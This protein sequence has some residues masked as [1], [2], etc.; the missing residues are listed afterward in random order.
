M[1]KTL[2]IL[3]AAFAVAAAKLDPAAAADR[4]ND[5]ESSGDYFDEEEELYDDEEYYDEDDEE[6]SGDGAKDLIPDFGTTTPIPEVKDKVTNDDI[7]FDDNKKAEEDDE[8]YEYYNEYYE[9]DYGDDDIYEEDEKDLERNNNNDINVATVEKE[10]IIEREETTVNKDAD[11]SGWYFFQLSYIYI[12]LASF[13]VTF[14]LAL[15]V[16]YVCRRNAVQR[17]HKLQEKMAP[18]VVDP[19]AY[20]RRPPPMATP[21]V[22]SYQRVPTSTKELLAGEGPASSQHTALDMQNR[23]LLT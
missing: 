6:G 7:H 21:I 23:P 5:I 4:E 18:F 12:M 16:F 22:K 8:L 9:E 20:N 13:L 14:A 1:M 3:L 19:R 15:T 11:D 17:R 2:L 10:I